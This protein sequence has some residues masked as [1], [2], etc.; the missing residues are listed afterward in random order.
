MYVKK[1]YIYSFHIAFSF[2]P[3][4]I[5]FFL[6]SPPTWVIFH[7][8]NKIAWT[9]VQGS[10]NTK[11]LIEK[12]EKSDVIGSWK[13]VVVVLYISVIIFRPTMFV[14]PHNKFLLT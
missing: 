7:L 6:N 8:A 9:I 4:A 1:N 3:N 13:M 10:W 12:G 11:W 14:R 2:W 5:F